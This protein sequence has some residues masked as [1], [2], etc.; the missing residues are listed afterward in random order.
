M[1]KQDPR[2]DS[3][4]HYLVANELVLYRRVL[5]EQVALQELRCKGRWGGRWPGLPGTPSGRWTP[6]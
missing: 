5:L 6:R 3:F 1:E 2:L 4:N